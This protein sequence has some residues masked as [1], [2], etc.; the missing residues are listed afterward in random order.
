MPEKDFAELLMRRLGFPHDVLKKMLSKQ[1]GPKMQGHPPGGVQVQATGAGTA[2]KSRTSPAV[3]PE[4]LP[5][6]PRRA[7]GSFLQRSTVFLPVQATCKVSLGPTLLCSVCF[8]PKGS[9]PPVT[10]TSPR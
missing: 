3:A 4:V 2:P 7:E 8:S 1:H 9:Q 10:P 6:G 5:P